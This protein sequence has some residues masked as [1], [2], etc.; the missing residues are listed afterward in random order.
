[1]KNALAP[2]FLRL[3]L[4]ILMLAWCAP[5]RAAVVVAPTAVMLDSPEATQQL[6]ITDV[7]PERRLDLTRTAAY[8]SLNP[9]IATVDET[10]L[11][12]PR[13]EGK[14]EILVKHGNEQLRVPV[15]VTGLKEPMPIAFETQII[16]ILTKAGCNSGGCHG[17]A[18]GQNGFKLSVFGFDPPEDHHALV[19][20]G[21]GRRFFPAAPDHSLL[22]R[23]ATGQLPHGGGQKIAPDSLPYRRVLRWLR[24][25]ARYTT[26]MASPVVKI[27][28]EPEQ[29]I[30]AFGGTQ[31]LRVT[32]IDAAGRSHCVTMEAEY[33]SNA[34]NIADVDRRGWI[35]ASD[36]PGEAAIL[37]R[38]MGHVA[39]CRITLPRPGVTFPRPP[40]VNF[41][42]RHVWNHLTRLGIA[43]S[44]LADDATFLRRVYLDTI[45]TLPTPGEARAFL[46]STEPN[47]RAKLIDQL[48]ERPEYAD[49]W[50]MLW[51]DLLRVDRDKVT[52]QGAVAITRW[53]RRQF[54]E[55][56]PY[57][58]F[59]RDILTAQGNLNGEGPAAVYK[60][61]D[62]PEEMGRSFS[63]LFLGVRIQCAQCHHHPSDRWGQDDY[64]ALAGFF[65]GLTRKNLPN[66]NVSIV[67]HGGADLANPRTKKAVPA[68]GLGAAPA[69]FAALRDRRTALANWLTAPE[70]PFF[71]TAIAN[72]LWDHYFGRG[73]VEP[74]DDL[75][76]TNP[77]SNEPLLNDLVKHM[78][79]VKFD[80]RAFTRTLLNSRVYQLSAST[81]PSNVA[82]VQ[83]FSHAA[84]KA[85]PAEVL[86]DSIGQVTGAPEKFN[87][88][89]DG[90][91]AVQLWDNRIPSYFFHIF[92]R[93]VRA[94]VCSCERG[95]EPSI[96]QA[97]HLMNSPE[98]ME[99]MRGRKGKVRLLAESDKTPAD[100]LDELYLMTLARFPTAKEKAL[101]LEAF[102]EAGAN[103]RAAIEDVLWVLLNSKEFLY[104]Q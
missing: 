73:L 60:V 19:V 97:L 26:P 53:L 72:R 21:R 56:R 47:K 38:Y 10:G 1:M 83:N 17:K 64:W 84:A 58:A 68:R 104:N 8:Q 11:V 92:G 71:A 43:P 37:A 85:L 5:L 63:Q 36:K 52:P 77:A 39:V 44:D 103:R 69:E 25:G 61:F 102:T 88:W 20:E 91:R 82:D 81:N 35:Q 48:L 100:L 86:L 13:G 49:Y 6:L 57:D 96:A 34:G 30:L 40:E 32:A 14:A 62:T 95:N 76:A 59:V 80:L 87:G 2:V 79:E 18:E 33:A 89:P 65:T 70:N 15:E 50:T 31:Q 3:M 94:T 16:P 75:R 7:T 90:Y 27:V 74:L 99:K 23:K 12:T 22:L 54:A 101:M 93:P 55:N 66:V 67:A 9:Q 51:S 29:Q 42:D 46:A 45:G 78:R 41:I 28:V 24:E 4:T 98:L